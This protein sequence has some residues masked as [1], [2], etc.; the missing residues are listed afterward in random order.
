MRTLFA[1]LLL[2]SC[3]HVFPQSHAN[4]W[5][6]GFNA[7][8]DFSNGSPVFRQG[9]L[10]ILEGSAAISDKNGNLQ[11]YT[12]GEDV[13]DANDV[14]MPNGTGLTGSNTST[15]NALIVPKP[16]SDSIYFLFT[17]DDPYRSISRAHEGIRYSEINM[18]LRGG[19]GDITS[20]KNI[21]VLASATEKITAV[22]HTN[23]KDIWLIVHALNSNAYHS[24][25]VSD[26]GVSTTPVVS[27]IGSM[28][29]SANGGYRG[30][31]KVSP[32]GKHLAAALQ[33]LWRTELFDFDPST[34]IVS[35]QITIPAPFPKT[36]GV[37]SYEPYG[38]EF[39]P[40][41][42]FLYLSH[43][44]SY[45]NRGAIYQYDLLQYDSASIV[46]SAT[47]LTESYDEKGALQLAP[48][49]KIYTVDHLNYYIGAIEAP[50]LPGTACNYKDSV[51]Y[52]G[53]WNTILG[54]PSFIQSYFTE[55]NIL[56]AI[57]V[58]GA[59]TLLCDGEELILQAPVAPGSSY[60]W[61]NGD[62]SSQFSVTQAGI[63]WITITDSCIT[64]TDT[65]EVNYRGV[66]VIDLGRDTTICFG[67]E[68]KIDLSQPATTY[69]WQD[70][71]STPAYSIDAAGTYWVSAT[72]EC[73]S[74]HDTI[75]V[76]LRFPPEVYLG[77]DGLLCRGSTMILD[78]ST[79]NASYVWQDGTT[80]HYYL[81]REGGDYWVDVDN[82]CAID[83]DSVY[84]V[85]R[86]PPHVDLGPDTSIC[87][88]TALMLNASLPDAVYLWQDDSREPFYQVTETGR[89]EVVISNVCGKKHEQISIM[90]NDCDCAFYVPNS[91]TPNSDGL[92]DHFQPVRSCEMESFLLQIFSRWGEII[93]ES[94][95]PDGKWNGTLN[96]HEL[97][98]DAYVWRLVYNT[99]Y[100]TEGE[101][102]LQGL[103]YLIR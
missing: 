64:Y 100:G 40:N 97:E 81:V 62:T 69:L 49:G 12:D 14:V 78:A 42:R 3:T 46:G 76:G 53:G 56:P 85:F 31:M 92:N 20:K 2:F 79:E 98:Q 32:D 63:Y 22:H 55:E 45:G 13:F 38:V 80:E 51:L 10:V 65:V 101:K 5:F 71:T 19:S 35:N 36:G 61:Q 50:N 39:S 68:I 88:G 17:A 33:G 73:G 44:I 8:M 99:G 83:R 9:A 26:T 30:A 57:D 43:M 54:L 25:L 89:Y 66:P 41:G 29:D 70:G 34:G 103:V 1:L 60:A 27:P 47:L 28:L 91:F 11:F 4:N 18:G 24:Y 58:L 7:G 15:Q 84:A 52:L 6:F 23:K 72:H 90:V 67:D 74:S 21:S 59:D 94:T 75:I 87:S 48:D 16:C 102:K 86:Y 95:D 93:Y 37:L 82:H 96:N 77:E